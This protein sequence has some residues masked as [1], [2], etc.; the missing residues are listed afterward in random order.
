M[1]NYY[2]GWD[3]SE[4]NIGDL[5]IIQYQVFDGEGKPRR[6]FSKTGYITEIKPEEIR[7][8][9]AKNVSRVITV[10][11]I[12]DPVK[13]LIIINQKNFDAFSITT[14]TDLKELKI[15]ELRYK[16]REVE[17]FDLPTNQRNPEEG[18]TN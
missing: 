3:V 18:E 9:I 11:D 15:T 7:I 13:S 14:D 16:P 10:E 17:Y 1:I 8:D 4:I 2:L 12:G 5:A 6:I